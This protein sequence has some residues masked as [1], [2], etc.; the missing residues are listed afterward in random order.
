MAN[1]VEKSKNLED[2][3]KNIK[4]KNKKQVE[5][6]VAKANKAPRNIAL[7]VNGTIYTKFGDKDDIGAKSKGLTLA[8]ISSARVTTPL[9]GTVK[10]AG[11]F[12]HYK[13]ILI[14]EHDDGYHSLIA[15]LSEIDTVVGAQLSAGEPVGVSNNSAESKIYY[16]LRKNGEPINP[17]KLLL[18]QAKQENIKHD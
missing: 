10:F 6:S 12:K 5:T 1:L 16:E 17:Q 11:P 3:M 2:L 15:G 13:Q 7:P 8:T 18:A 14:I 9:S 4:E